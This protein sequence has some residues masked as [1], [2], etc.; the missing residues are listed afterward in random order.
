MREHIQ[1]AGWT[2]RDIAEFIYERA[3]IRRAE[4]GDVGKGAVVRDRGDSIYTAL[5]LAR[6]SARRGGGR[7]RRRLRR[8]HSAL[9]GQQ[10]QGGDRG[11]RRLRR[12]RAAE[13]E[14]I[15]RATACIELNS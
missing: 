15:D 14:R 12:L 8:R 5:G 4:W 13:G 6:A 7:P 10:D 3:R 2:K 1:A 11:D 9:D